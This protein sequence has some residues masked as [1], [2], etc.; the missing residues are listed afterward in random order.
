MIILIILLAIL[1]IALVLGLQGLVYW[2]M[3]AFICWAFQIPFEFT[4]AHGVAI[5]FIVSTLT[6]IFNRDKIKVNIKD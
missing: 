2:G 5:A 3:G 4:F 1:I 6:S